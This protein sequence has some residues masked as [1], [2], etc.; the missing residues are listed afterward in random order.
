MRLCLW[1]CVCV[2]VCVRACVRAWRGVLCV[3]VCYYNFFS[4]LL[5]FRLRLIGSELGA[6]SH[7][8]RR[9]C[10]I[11][12]F[13]PLNAYLSKYNFNL[14]PTNLLVCAL[15]HLPPREWNR[16]WNNSL[17]LP[18]SLSSRSLSLSYIY[19]H[20]YTYRQKTG[21]EIM[22]SQMKDREAGRRKYDC[23][24]HTMKVD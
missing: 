12:Y 1:L 15:L 23:L 8:P 2:C 18:L 3:C 13:T 5:V 6:L 24:K 19:I 4:S 11:A 22:R 9:T 16:G 14:N 20:T 17:S 7:V 21:S 10:T